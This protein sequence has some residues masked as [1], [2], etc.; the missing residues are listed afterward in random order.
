LTSLFITTSID[1]APEAAIGVLIFVY[2][3]AA[4][5]NTRIPERA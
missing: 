5:F 4:W 1:T 3:I 2:L